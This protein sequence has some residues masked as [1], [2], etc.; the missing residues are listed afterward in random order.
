M[1]ALSMVPVSEPVK[2]EDEYLVGSVRIL[3]AHNAGLQVGV[4]LA[5]A[6]HIAGVM[7]D[8]TA[9]SL[10]QSEVFDA[11]GEVANIIGGGVKGI[12]EGE[13]HL[14]LPRVELIASPEGDFDCSDDRVDVHFECEGQPLWVRYLEHQPAGASV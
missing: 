2:A 8:T 5:L 6:Q 14:S 13:S 4:P 7:F 11:I 3:G 1:L 10:E 12:A 9:E